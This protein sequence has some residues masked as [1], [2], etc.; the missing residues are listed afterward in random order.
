M[1]WQV[2]YVY[3]LVLFAIALFFS[4]RV[5]LDMVAALVIIALAVPG[6]LTPAQAVAGFGNPLVMLIAGLFVVSEGLS[7]TGVA[8][9]IGMQIAARASSNET[10]LLLLLMPVVAVLS[11]FMSSTGV[12]ALFVPVVLSLARECG[13]PASRLLLPVSVASL[14]GGMLTL[15]GTPPNLV[16][17]SALLDAGLPGFAFFDFAMIGGV[18]LV[19]TLG[20]VVL[21]GRK[22]LP[23]VS[24]ADT[25]EGGRRLREMA[26]DYG[27]ENSLYRLRI[28]PGSVLDG[29]T[30]SDAALRREFGLTVVAMERQERLLV[31]LYPVVQETRM[32]EG[33][34]LVVVIAQADLA[35][36]TG[37]LGLEDLGFP[38]G[39]QR[40]Y[41]ESFG[42]A[43]ALVTPESPLI[44]KSL[45][46]LRFRDRY[47]FNVISVRRSR[48]PMAL[49]FASEPLQGGDI[50]L[51]AG[52]WNDIERLNGPH[53]DLVLLALP[54]E[55]KQRTW[56]ANQA[57][58]A[59]LI[60]LGMLFLMVT[61]LTS[62]LVA[63][64]LAAFAMVLTRCVAMN[65]VY[66][67]MN[68]QT[69]VL[70]AGMLPLADAL[71]VTGGSAVIV[72]GLAGIF[73]D[74]GPQVAMAGLFI[75]TS[76]LSQFI[77]NTATTVLVAP[78]ALDLALDLGLEPTAFLMAVAIAAS[79]AFATPIASPVN[80]L[81]VTPG[82]YRFMDF[83]RFGVPLQLIALVIT[84]ILVPLL[85]G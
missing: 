69:L 47:H 42:F 15:I 73:T 80:T 14:V 5:R 36:A 39:L 62:N 8:P 52:A 20:F 34:T 76:L 29:Q 24:A 38:H 37:K 18:I 2:G 85:F 70:V 26:S 41:H 54:D 48:K 10:H 71:E 78:I 49:D 46:E 61:G 21:V 35:A 23:V 81:I 66:S 19:M 83:V 11:A 63:V 1:D 59:V 4:N 33:D 50:L 13:L 28:K 25:P 67:S 72:H 43:E 60:T 9:W 53:H 68:W 45:Y 84:L 55:I 27:I 64:M 31:S 56:H 22:L 3:A 44:G 17:N 30:V 79:T 32:H 74:Y 7:R 77:S 40:R 51:V 12:V 6:I 57:P 82:N 16:V 65:E 58:W 75:L